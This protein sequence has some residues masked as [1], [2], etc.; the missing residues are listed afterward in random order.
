MEY[1]LTEEGRKG[2]GED[3][4][5]GYRKTVSSSV[6]AR[7]GGPPVHT[8]GKGELGV[9]WGGQGQLVKADFFS[10]PTLSYTDQTQIVRVGGKHLY[11]LTPLPGLCHSR[12]SARITIAHLHTQLE[13]LEVRQK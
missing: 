12:L 7:N 5:T 10:F 2:V 13:I 9:F 3:T 11:P 4:V 1:K 6:A 8:D